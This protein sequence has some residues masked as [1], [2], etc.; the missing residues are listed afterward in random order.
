[1]QALRLDGNQLEDLNG[2][3]TTQHHLQWLNASHNRLQ[4]FDYAFVPKSL[5]WLSLRGNAVEEL[6]NYYDMED[7]FALAHLDVA[8]NRLGRLDRDSL[9]GSL[10]KVRT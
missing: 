4:W 3:L 7:G 8:G 1:M 10:K 9:L 2:L 6:G 5:L